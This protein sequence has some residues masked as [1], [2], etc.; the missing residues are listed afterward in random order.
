MLHVVICDDN[1]AELK[2]LKSTVQRIMDR[3]LVRYNIEEYDSGEKLLKASKAFDLV[4]LDV[5]V[6]GKSGV[7]IGKLIYKSS[8]YT[9]AIFQTNFVQNYQD[10]VNKSYA[11]AFLEKPIQIDLL[12]EQIKEFMISKE[13]VQK[14]HVEFK[15]VKYVLH[16]IEAEKEL[17]VLPVDDII[18]FEYI[19]AQKKI[20]IVTGNQIYVYSETMKALE[21]RMNPLGFETSCR[22]LLINIE[23]I[24]KI[25]GYT[26]LMSNGKKLPL[27][28]RRV[29][30]FKERMN[31]FIHN[32]Y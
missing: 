1:I 5:V 2:Q 30:E 26:I 28:Q 6:S 22:G 31:E 10:A 12:E 21:K 18:Y 14:V 15:N 24:M 11:F 23:K 19:K 4:F 17:L 20:A 29:L 27:S 32:S 3:S 25:K 9:Q 7:A 8:R 16:G 13:K